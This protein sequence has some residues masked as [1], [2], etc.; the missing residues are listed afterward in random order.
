MT[1]AV[2]MHAF[3]FELANVY[4]NL[5]NVVL[6]VAPTDPMGSKAKG[7][8]VNSHYDSTLGTVGAS[9]CASTGGQRGRGGEFVGKVGVAE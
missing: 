1:G 8:L 7:L 9:D 6:R 2:T 3:K 5:S 4:N